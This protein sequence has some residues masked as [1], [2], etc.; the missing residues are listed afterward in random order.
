M[1][2]GAGRDQNTYDNVANW[3]PEGHE[4]IHFWREK[5]HYSRF[6]QRLDSL[7]DEDDSLQFFLAADLPETYQT[8]HEYYGMR[9]RRLSRS[10]F[11]RSAE[12]MSFALAD[13]ILL[14][15][16]SRLLGSTWSSFSELA[17]R[18]STG[19]SNIE[20]SGKDF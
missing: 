7:L 11:D 20:M 13:A 4:L 1:E 19:L 8:F 18:L 12:Q 17:M 10:Q 9:L 15:R 6:I 14:S 3:T 5:S 2:A 16:C